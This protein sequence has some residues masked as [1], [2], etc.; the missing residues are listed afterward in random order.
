V[1]IDRKLHLHG[2]AGWDITENQDKYQVK[3]NTY[4][5]G[6]L[7][8][9]KLEEF[10]APVA[11]LVTNNKDMTFEIVGYITRE[12]FMKEHYETDYGY[13]TRYAVNQEQLDPI[14]T[15]LW[16]DEHAVSKR[17]QDH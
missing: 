1:D 4:R 16:R 11:I 12:R 14:T 3:Y 17:S 5:N 2:D 7:Y 8:F 15:L 9:A 10:K 13:G 6:Q